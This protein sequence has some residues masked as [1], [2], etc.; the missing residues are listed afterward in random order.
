MFNR[1]FF[2]A[3]R[4]WNKLHL[5]APHNVR[6]FLW[7]QILRQQKIAQG[8]IYEKI[9][10][11]VKKFNI[12]HTL[13]FRLMNFPYSNSVESYKDRSESVKGTVS[14]D[15][16]P[17]F[18]KTHSPSKQAKTVLRSLLFSRRYLRK[19]GTKN[20]DNKFWTINRNKV[21]VCVYMSNSKMFNIW[22]KGGGLPKAKIP[23]PC[24]LRRHGNFKLCTRI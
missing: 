20:V 1:L 14:R 12:L 10:Y 11:F 7:R 5:A 3:E 8:N 19:T 21:F 6:K 22:K 9:V 13:V 23:C 15:F 24:C 16:R 18:V 17:L 4:Y 2:K